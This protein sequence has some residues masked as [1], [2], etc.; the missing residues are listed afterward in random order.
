VL[1][2]RASS[3]H[4]DIGGH[5][6]VYVS[7]DPNKVEE[8]DCRVIKRSFCKASQWYKRSVKDV[9]EDVGFGQ[10]HKTFYKDAS[11][12]CRGDSFLIIRRRHLQEWDIA[13]NRDQWD[14]YIEIWARFHRPWLV[15][16]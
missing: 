13:V 11:S 4:G 14:R 12:I 2:T 1:A 9:V 3:P 10:L 5:N 6:L 7:K 8:N 15:R 16:D